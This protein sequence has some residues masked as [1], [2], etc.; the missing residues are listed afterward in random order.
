MTLEI[1]ALSVVVIISFLLPLVIL[2]VLI[3]KNRTQWRSIIACFLCGGIIYALM[4]WGAKEHG[5]AWLFNNTN[6]IRLMENQYILYLFVVA[7][8]GAVLMVF[9]QMIAMALLFKRQITMGKVIALSVGYSMV[10]SAFLIGIGSI[11]T[12]I[13]LIKETDMQLATTANDLF[14]SGY[15]R[16][17]LLIIEAG[18]LV[19][20][21]YFFGRKMYIRGGIVAILCNTLI[22]FL[23]GF[24]IAFSL[25]D[26]YEVFDRSIALV[27]VHVVLT[28][29]AVA[30]VIIGNVLKNMLYSE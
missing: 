23:P 21:A 20:L 7:F 30:S 8:A 13:E 5:L 24:F 1:V 26:Y 29:S 9:A 2:G 28:A 10:E 22:A 12:I 16:I 25:P 15:E 17:L 18:I 27:M 14:L 11:N 6:F 3:K 19:V 4:Q